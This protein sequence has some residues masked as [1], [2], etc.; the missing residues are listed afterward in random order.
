MLIPYFDA[1]CDTIQRIDPNCADGE[2]S[3]A[4]FNGHLSLRRLKKFSPCGQFFALFGGA[5]NSPEHQQAEFER[6]Y[7]A[8][9]SQTEKNSGAIRRCQ[10]AADMSLAFGENKIAAFLS[11]EGAEMLGCRADALDRAYELGVRAIMPVWNNSNVLCGSCAQNPDDGLSAAGV[12]FVGRAY[13][14][15]ILIDVSHMSDKG[16][17]DV[18][19]L[20]RRF[21]MPVI[22]SHSN[23]RSVCRHRRNLTDDM[24]KKIIQTGGFAGINLYA[25]FLVES[26]ECRISHIIAHTDHF[27][28][29]G[30]EDHICLGCDFDGCDKLPVGIA[31][32]SDLEKL[33]YCMLLHGYS[34]KTVCKIFGK[35]MLRILCSV[36]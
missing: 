26:G 12:E 33:F 23:S 1:H 10:S 6:Q 2:K 32:V 7:A 30:G 36:I 15:G 28:R 9:I 17:Y 27:I 5:D 22:A 21:N 25:D 24:F 29:L 3:L 4:E 34:K 35:N 19:S 18:Y 14:K 31:S 13:E 16:F 8:Y 20:S 11:V